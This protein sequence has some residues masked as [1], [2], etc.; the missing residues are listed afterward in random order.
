MANC[1]EVAVVT[2]AIPLPSIESVAAGLHVDGDVVVLT[3]IS[4]PRELRETGRGDLFTVAVAD[5][6]AG[7]VTVRE[8]RDIGNGDLWAVI[9][10]A[11]D[12][13]A[14]EVWVPPVLY[15][16]T[17]HLVA[18]TAALYP[19]CTVTVTGRVVRRGQ[20]PTVWAT[21]ISGGPQ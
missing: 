16:A 12:R 5:D 2:A 20:R 11:C 4:I 8:L 18:P 10:L 7:A 19:P 14:V 3:G 13:T 1:V 15:P 6:E 17:E 9:N 21:D